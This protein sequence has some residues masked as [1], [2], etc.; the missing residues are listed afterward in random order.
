MYLIINTR[1]LLVNCENS[2]IYCKIQKVLYYINKCFYNI[3]YE[4]DELMGFG[5]RLSKFRKEKGYTQK[6]LA[7]KLNVSQQ[8]ISNI[9]RNAS[10]PD[11][12]F[13]KDLADLYLVSI[14]ELIGREVVPKDYNNL[15][16]KI[17]SVV[18]Q[19]DDKGKELSLGLVNEVAQHQGN[20][21]AK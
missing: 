6:D 9:E 7:D 15:E 4:V 16:Q 17:M 8:V 13:L 5:E 14:D 12:I 18:E 10:N 1:I 11:I 21:N 20:K 3:Y 2:Q 19:M